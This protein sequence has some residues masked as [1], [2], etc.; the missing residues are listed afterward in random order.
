VTELAEL[1]REVMRLVP[2]YSNEIMEYDNEKKLYDNLQYWLCRRE[3]EGYEYTRGK[4]YIDPL[5][6][7]PIP[8]DTLRESDLEKWQTLIRVG[9]GRPLARGEVAVWYTTYILTPSTRTIPI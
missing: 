5:P 3:S 8:R 1:F 7:S 9:E 4:S 2:P 6:T